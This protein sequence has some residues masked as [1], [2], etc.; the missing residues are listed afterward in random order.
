MYFR[1]FEKE[2]SIHLTLLPKPDKELYFPRIAK[3]FEVVID[4]I[5]QIRKYKSEHKLPM[6]AEVKKFILKTKEPKKLQ[7]YLYLISQVM[8]IKEIRLK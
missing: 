5:S 7:K 2:K 4:A 6:N 1:K 3:D 8:N